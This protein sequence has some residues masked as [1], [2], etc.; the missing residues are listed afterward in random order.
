MKSFTALLWKIVIFLITKNSLR[1]KIFSCN[2][3]HLNNH[4]F[5]LSTR[6]VYY[7]IYKI[8]EIY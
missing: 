1:K 7:I 4:F 6:T 5:I 3:C 8:I 2:E